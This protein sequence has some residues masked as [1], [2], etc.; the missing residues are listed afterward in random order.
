MIL[1][2]KYKEIIYRMT[3]V[4]TSYIKSYLTDFTGFDIPQLCDLITNVKYGRDRYTG[5]GILWCIRSTGTHLIFPEYEKD[6][7]HFPSIVDMNERFFYIN[8]EKETE[9]KEVSYDDAQEI[10]RKWKED[11]TC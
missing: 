7:S 4:A 2:E 9:F 8:L 3:K 10:V 1:E 6:I 5:A 11:F